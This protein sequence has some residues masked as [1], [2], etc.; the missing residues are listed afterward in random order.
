M[1]QI[2]HVTPLE[3]RTGIDIIK[4]KKHIW[5]QC[6]S[7]LEKC[8]RT[9]HLACFFPPL[10]DEEDQHWGESGDNNPDFEY[11]REL[12]L[13]KRRQ[14][15]QRELER[16]ELEEDQPS[17][18]GGREV[19]LCLTSTSFRKRHSGHLAV[20]RATCTFSWTVRRTLK[21]LGDRKGLGGDSPCIMVYGYAPRFLGAFS[22]I[23]V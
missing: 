1:R 20:R 13:E 2:P 14:Q 5:H 8:Q 19:S 17:D 7:G 18:M 21:K 11:A 3:I 12:T 6:K 9:N 22:A 15:L 4:K 16:M 10:T 23:L